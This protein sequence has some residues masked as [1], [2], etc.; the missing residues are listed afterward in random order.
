MTWGIIEDEETETVFEYQLTAA[1]A[2]QRLDILG[3]TAARSKH[4]FESRIREML[5]ERED[6]DE[7]SFYHGPSWLP[8]DERRTFTQALTFERWGRGVREFLDIGISPYI[9]MQDEQD[10]ELDPIVRF[11]V[12]SNDCSNDDFEFGFPCCDP[13][14]LIRSVL[15]FTDDSTPV[16]LDYTELVH[17]GYYDG[18]ED[19][20]NRARASKQRE[21]VSTAR[22][23]VLTEGRSDV[24]FLQKS[25]DLLYPHLSELFTFNDF[26]GTKHE[27]GV[28]GLVKTVKAFIASGVANRVVAIFDND[29]AA[30]EALTSI[31][32]AT[33]PEQFRLL[34]FPILSYAIDYPT[35]G[36][37]G[38]FN[39]DVNGLAGGIELY[40]GLDVLRQNGKLTRVQWTG[41]TSKLKQYQGELLNK[42]RLQERFREKLNAAT[43]EDV[44]WNSDDW[45]G[46]RL[47]LES[48]FGAFLP[49][50]NADAHR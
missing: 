46:M 10:R 13:R 49:F 18:S 2:R 21:F 3:F 37:Q 9:L 26:A 19:L 28:G 24:E 12:T 15:E 45:I 38:E 29:T 31:D 4:E 7:L 16:V 42:K 30:A 34:Q 25:L 8:D 5:G 41:Y 22:T 23:I 17:S 11:I 27:G 6:D 44:D 39:L 36:P 33:L 1:K 50:E 32:P 35:T 47:I 40:F 14:I 48:I 20:A 43:P